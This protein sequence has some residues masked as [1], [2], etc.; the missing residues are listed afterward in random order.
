[1]TSININSQ[2]NVGIDEI[3]NGISTLETN[4]LEQFMQK[5]SKIVAKRKANSL[6]KKESDLLLNINNSIPQIQQKRFELLSAKLNNKTISP[7]EHN[8]MLE[9]IDFLE[10]KHAERLKNLIELSQF[11]NVSLDTLMQQLQLSIIPNASK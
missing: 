5:I 4:E 6:S 2:V 8:E 10:L 11:R 9:L 3:L 7:N 1:M